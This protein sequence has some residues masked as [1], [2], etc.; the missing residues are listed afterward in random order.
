[1]CVSGGEY[2][3]SVKNN[4]CTNVEGTTNCNAA[5]STTNMYKKYLNN[6]A[7]KK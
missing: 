5:T 1:M 4:L 6:Q 2:V 3:L 7:N